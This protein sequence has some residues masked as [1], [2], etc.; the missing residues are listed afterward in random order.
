MEE[1]GECL[2]ASHSDWANSPRGEHVLSLTASFLFIYQPIFI[3][4]TRIQMGSYVTKG[5]MRRA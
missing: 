4:V 1:K 2:S 5:G 3:P